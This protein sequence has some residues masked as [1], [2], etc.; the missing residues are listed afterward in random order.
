MIIE[1]YF[2]NIP[3][4][5]GSSSVNTT[6]GKAPNFCFKVSRNHFN[7]IPCSL[8]SRQ[9]AKTTVFPKCLFETRR[10]KYSQEYGHC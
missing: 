8:E 6:L 3:W 1:K 2:V 7:E 5:A 4:N 10:I 9:N